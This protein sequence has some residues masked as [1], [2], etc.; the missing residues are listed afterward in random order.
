[1]PSDMI[2][3]PVTTSFLGPVSTPPAQFSTFDR[4]KGKVNEQ[5]DR[6][7]RIQEL[8]DHIWRHQDAVILKDVLRLHVHQKKGKETRFLKALGR[9]YGVTTLLTSIGFPRDQTTPNKNLMKFSKCCKA[10]Q[11]NKTYE[12]DT[13][14]RR[15]F[16]EPHAA[17]KKELAMTLGMLME[18]LRAF[19]SWESQMRTVLIARVQMSP[20]VKYTPVER[21]QLDRFYDDTYFLSKELLGSIAMRIN[22]EVVKP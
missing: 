9:L 14:R 15:K 22:I 1:M 11:L 20:E 18:V 13:F 16:D 8:P 2:K 4:S 7:M 12:I 6:A 17:R 19:D 3:G 5:V 21:E 10:L